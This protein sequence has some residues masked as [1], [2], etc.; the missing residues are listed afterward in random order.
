MVDNAGAAGPAG[1]NRARHQQLLGRGDCQRLLQLGRVDQRVVHFDLAATGVG[2]VDQQFPA[3]HLALAL[4]VARQRQVPLVALSVVTRAGHERLRVIGEVVVEV[5]RR[6]LLPRVVDG[7]LQR[8]AG[9]EAAGGVPE[10][11]RVVVPRL[12]FGINVRTV[13]TGA[14]RLRH[15]FVAGSEAI[16]GAAVAARERVELARR[17]GG[18]RGYG[19]I[20]LERVGAALGN[21]QVVAQRVAVVVVEWQVG[22][23]AAA[24]AQFD[25][26]AAVNLASVKRLPAECQPVAHEAAAVAFAQLLANVELCVR[27]H[28]LFVG[29]RNPA[30]QLLQRPFLAS[31]RLF[32]ICVIFDPFLDDFEAVLAHELLVS[33]VD[34]P[35]I[36]VGGR[37]PLLGNAAAD[38]VPVLL[39]VAPENGMLLPVAI[40]DQRR[41]LLGS[42]LER[43]TPLD[44]DF[45]HL[46]ILPQKRQRDADRALEVNLPRHRVSRRIAVALAGHRHLDC[47]AQN[48]HRDGGQQ[49]DANRADSAEDAHVEVF[50]ALEQWW[51]SGRRR[52]GRYSRLVSLRL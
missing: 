45:V 41:Q 5:R 40:F 33:G 12:E 48:H 17:T 25:G 24:D 1:D 28:S 11:G 18:V 31:Q 38:R 47:A 3:G 9:V 37:R 36:D 29:A 26:G 34:S 46:D 10:G 43:P 21:P 30:G 32:V 44:V 42:R 20:E 35:V 13:R 8:K 2:A 49:Q 7:V 39:D 52:G 50:D 15:V 16:D 23:A 27:H 22:R 14:V 6:Q 19:D 4:A 51:K